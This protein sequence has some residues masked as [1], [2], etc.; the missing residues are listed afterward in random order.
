[1]KDRAS[2]ANIVV[3]VVAAVLLVCAAFGTRAMFDLSAKNQLHLISRMEEL[4]LA[5][6]VDEEI[7]LVKKM[8]TSPLISRYMQDPENEELLHSAI[9]EI[10]SYN[11]FFTGDTFSLSRATMR[12][13]VNGDYL[14]TLDQGN[15]DHARLFAALQS[16]EDCIF[17]ALWDEDL[18]K[19]VLWVTGVVRDERGSAVGLVGTGIDM[20]YFE[21][22]IFEH[23]ENGVTMYFY[24]ETGEVTGAADARLVGEMTPV[25]TLLPDLA[26]FDMFPTD[27]SYF[28]SSKGFYE[29]SPVSSFG[30]TMVLFLP[31]SLESAF[32]SSAVPL[33]GLLLAVVVF[34]VYGT[35]KGCIE[36]LRSLHGAVTTISTGSADLT[37]R[38]AS[39]QGRSLKLIQHIEAGFNAF[40][41]KLQAIIATIKAAGQDHAK[42]SD[43]LGEGIQGITKSIAQIYPHVEQTSEAINGANASVDE[44]ALSIE[45]IC[46]EIASLD[47]MVAQQNEQIAQA[48][49][50]IEQMFANIDA[51]NSSVGKLS[52]SFVVLQANTGESVA[53]QQNVNE[54]ILKI[55]QD[56]EI[57]QEANLTISSIASQ[58]NLLSMNAAIEAAH[59]GEAGKGFSV[60]ADEIRTLSETSSE[61]SKTIG[62]QLKTIQDAIA[63]IATVSAQS[64]EVLLT[65][66]HNITDAD[67]LVHSIRQAMDEQ[68]SGSHQV[69]SSLSTLR[70]T[71]SQVKSSSTQIGSTNKVIMGE[72]ESLKAH[73]QDIK[74]RMDDVMVRSKV[75][76]EQADGLSV[77]LSDTQQSLLRITDQIEQFKT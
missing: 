28:K 24:D 75:I 6:D 71:S 54:R 59:A 25:T 68:H 16:S 51:V 61:Q 67:D 3:L 43:K 32:K 9:E 7:M 36:P 29:I 37:K 19:E 73:A 53:K 41:A 52:E 45:Q 17:Q 50:A 57:L 77:L 66:S 5:A 42:A 62:Q 34:F 72:T 18:G 47:A 13:R 23:L 2:G 31:F 39:A 20:S 56:S 58:T 15:S 12:Y 55:Q 27:K 63:G 65:V 35:A 64:Q 38:L 44:I 11:D 22:L 60:V 46:S 14:Y 1:M 8:A 4:E 33:A 48:G 40:I 76:T 26:S 30:W 10:C 70:D 74:Q 49:A 21:T 69:L